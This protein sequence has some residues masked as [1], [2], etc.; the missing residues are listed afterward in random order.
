MP[1][2]LRVVMSCVVAPWWTLQMRGVMPLALILFCST[3]HSAVATDGD[4]DPDLMERVAKMK[5]KKKNKEPPMDPTGEHPLRKF[6]PKSLVCSACKMITKQFQGKVA[7]KIKAKM[8]EDQ[9]RKTFEAELPKACAASSYPEQM[10]VFD[11]EQGQTLGDMADTMRSGGRTLS[12]KRAGDDLKKEFLQACEH[13]LFVEFKDAL[14]EKLVSNPK[15]HGKDIDFTG[16]LCGPHQAQVCDGDSD[17]DD[18]DE[19]L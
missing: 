19:E 5:E 9:K 6:G 8:K 1:Q 17:E 7:R 14:L 15:Q 12:I 3:S 11:R 10:I 13:V 4:M 16:W 18:A 2:V